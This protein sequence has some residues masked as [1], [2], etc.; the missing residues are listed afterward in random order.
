MTLAEAISIVHELVDGAL[1]IHANG[2]ISRAGFS[3]RD[4]PQHF[5]MLGSMGLASSIGLGLAL[6]RPARQVVVCDGD[7]NVLMNMGTLAQIGARRPRNLLHICFDNGVHGSTGNQPTISRQVRL[8]EVARAAG[9]AEATRVDRPESL[10]RAVGD[11]CGRPGPA[12]LLVEIMPT[13]PD[14]PFPRVSIEPPV[15]AER[16]RAAAAEQ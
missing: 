10:R 4:A 2:M 9:Y 5:Y 8:E 11:L 7:G 6:A 14:P 1:V 3:N 13:L 12:F 15:L 16:F